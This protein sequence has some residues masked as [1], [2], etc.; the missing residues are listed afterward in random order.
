MRNLKK[1]LALVLALMM[2][3]SVM[4]FANA[5]T[6]DDYG[7][8][9]QIDPDYA[10]A[11]D[12]LSGLG[13]YKGSEQSFRPNAPITRE[14]MTALVY[15][16]L[17][18]DPDGED[19]KGY[20]DTYSEFADVSENGWAVGYINYASQMGWVAGVGGGNF[21]PKSNITGYEVAAILVR[22]LGRD[23][24]G[25]EI[26]GSDWKV[27]AATLAARLGVTKNLKGSLNADMTREQAAQLL[28][29]ALQADVY[30]Y[31]GLTY[32]TVGQS[33][34][35]QC[36]NLDKITGTITK[37]SND[38]VTVAGTLLYAVTGSG[39]TVAPATGSVTIDDSYVFETGRSAYV[40]VIKGAAANSYTAVSRPYCTDTVL[41]TVYDGDYAGWTT[42]G[43]DNFVAEAATPK[44]VVNGDVNNSYNAGNATV[45]RE[46]R[47]IDNNSD[48]KIDLVL[49]RKEVAKVVGEN[50]V[51][52][53][54]EGETT[55]VTVDGVINTATDVK[56][57]VGYEGLAA[58]DVVLVPEVPAAYTGVTYLTKATAVTGTKTDY[59]SAPNEHIVFNG[60]NYSK[61]TTGDLATGTDLDELFGT[62]KGTFG[63]SYTIYLSRGNY[64]VAAK[65]GET[66]T[67][68]G[69]A[70]L[71]D[72]GYTAPPTTSIS[73]DWSYTATLLYMDGTTAQVTTDVLYGWKGSVPT[74]ATAYKESNAEKSIL[75]MF[76][77]VGSTTSASGETVTKLTPNSKNVSDATF[78]G[79]PDI[80][81]TYYGD[82]NTVYLVVNADG[83]VSRY[84]GYSNMPKMS[85]DAEGTSS[86]EIKVAEG[87]T[88][89]AQYVYVVGY[90]PAAEDG[91]YVWAQSAST[92]TGANADGEYVIYTGLYQNGALV[93]LTSV[94]SKADELTTV[95]GYYKV[96]LTNGQVTGFTD[97]EETVAKS[98]T[99]ASTEGSGVITGSSTRYVLTA[100][101][102]VYDATGTALE[103]ASISAIGDGDTVTVILNSD[104]QVSAIYLTKDVA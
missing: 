40:W 98:I 48:G 68:T 17:A 3:L 1:I 103:S 31:N 82:N 28:F 101:C 37:G 45:G 88:S 47:L 42:K 71:V 38:E 6:F 11:V 9:D 89:L 58:G 33:L 39:T 80:N 41:A 51:T 2:A 95:P 73:G 32:V 30:D 91:Y 22:A 59:V 14:E 75:G 93:S 34:G 50:G 76:V 25:E 5:A 96:T 63:A 4:V 74:G 102:A 54:T 90:K 36:L 92:T 7:D 84:V 81:T 67:T 87:S 99:V 43:E 35:E 77:E 61:A 60:T 66:V 27:D 56:T 72:A 19:L 57:V 13:V 64:V 10:E 23:S 18:S 104:G 15:R 49:I 8:K 24:K 65:A 100:D 21:E 97:A 79:K 86:V 94:E 44:F 85:K 29:N 62:D 69:Y 78:T 55:K 52:T 16:T 83:T 70:V 26:E 46:T 12:T 20:Y 53:K